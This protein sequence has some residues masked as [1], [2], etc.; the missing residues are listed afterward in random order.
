VFQKDTGLG[1]SRGSG[2]GSSSSMV[3]TDGCM[4]CLRVSE[5]LVK[6]CGVQNEIFV[7]VNRAQYI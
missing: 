4:Q 1:L 7:Y 6:N 2:G 3:L 5:D